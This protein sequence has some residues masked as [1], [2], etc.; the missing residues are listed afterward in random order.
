MKV[1]KSNKSLHFLKLHGQLEASL[2]SNSGALICH[3]Y[4]GIPIVGVFHAY[5][6]NSQSLFMF[7]ESY[8][9]YDIY[10][11]VIHLGSYQVLKEH[12][13]IYSSVHISEVPC[14]HA[15]DIYVCT[16][17]LW[18]SQCMRYVSYME[19]FYISSFRCFQQGL[20]CLCSRKMMFVI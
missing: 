8:T 4:Y 12:C 18:I 15:R 10:T 3:Q 20:L 2:H 9:L 13:M 5:I 11:Y 16:F 19:G 6:I 1:V 17:Y 14:L 7:R